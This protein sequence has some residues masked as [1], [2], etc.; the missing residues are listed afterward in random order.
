MQTEGGG[1]G[2]GLHG[3]AY[4]KKPSAKARRIGMGWKDL[5]SGSPCAWDPRRVAEYYHAQ[6]FFFFFY[7][8]K[9]VLLVPPFLT[10]APILNSMRK[11]SLAEARKSRSGSLPWLFV[12]L[13]LEVAVPFSSSQ[14]GKKPRFQNPSLLFPS[15][16]LWMI[17]ENRNGGRS[18]FPVPPPL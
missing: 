7:K 3:L 12:G 4:G 13:L 16:R 10:F 15:F 2:G 8:K 14:V 11:I 6:L 1:R 17:L 5:Q 18:C 9:A